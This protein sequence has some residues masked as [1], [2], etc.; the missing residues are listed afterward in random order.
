M[1]RVRAAIL[2]ASGLVSQRMQQ[3]LSMHPWFELVAVA[4]RA[5]D[6][7]LSA[8]DWYLDEPRPQ[9]IDECDINILDIH[10]EHLSTKLLQ[11]N[12]QVV[13]SALPSQPAIEIEAGL[14]NAGLHVFSNA[15]AYRMHPDVALVVADVN[16]DA[17]IQPRDG[18]ALHACATNCT[19]GL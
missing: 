11:K 8:L 19:R 6:T 9:F 2:G 16:P 15:S 3:R 10:D 17:L 5:V 7:K 4:G 1:S 12:V 14:V 13:F 18:R